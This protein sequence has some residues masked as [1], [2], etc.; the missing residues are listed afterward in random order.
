ML[1]TKHPAAPL[2]RG[3]PYAFRTPDGNF[4]P[5]HIRQSPNGM[6][7]Q[8]RLQKTFYRKDVDSITAEVDE[9]F[10]LGKV[11]RDNASRQIAVRSAQGV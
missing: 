1:S 8:T 3:L 9:V 6:P 2:T 10:S 11:G 4:V 5:D 7:A